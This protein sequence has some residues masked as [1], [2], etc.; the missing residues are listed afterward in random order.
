MID[1]QQLRHLVKETLEEL[2]LF[3]WD[4]FNLVLGTIAHESKMG[5]YI[6][7]IKGPALGICQ[8]EPP[9]Y[10]DIVERMSSFHYGKVMQLSGLTSLKC[11]AAHLEWNLKLAIAM[12]RMHY[13]L[14]PKRLP[15]T[16]I[17]Y[18]KFWKKYY[19]T[20]LGAGTGEQFLDAYGMHI[21]PVE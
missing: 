13:Y 6:K 17:G 9:T 11:A 19:N 15:D 10:N 16:P 20:E 21:G 7:Q 18:A 8:M 3:S 1:N 12:C 2:D 4:A 14:V 5:E